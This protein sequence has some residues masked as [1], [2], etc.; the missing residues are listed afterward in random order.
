MGRSWKITG[1]PHGLTSEECRPPPKFDVYGHEGEVE[2]SRLT[3]SRQ[4]SR[5]YI[6]LPDKFPFILRNDAAPDAAG[7][8][9]HSTSFLLRKL[10]R[11]YVGNSFTKSLID[12]WCTQYSLGEFSRH[13]DSQSHTWEDEV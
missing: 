5:R 7:R 12:T 2:P 8:H 10:H 6:S 4:R 11:V 1:C 9:L 13:L 3:H